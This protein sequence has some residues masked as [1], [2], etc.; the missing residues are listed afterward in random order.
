MPCHMSWQSRLADAR[1]IEAAETLGQAR[2]LA[3]VASYGQ[4][5]RRAIDCDNRSGHYISIDTLA[6]QRRNH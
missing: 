1:R 5:L 4:P 6:C 3:R 2:E